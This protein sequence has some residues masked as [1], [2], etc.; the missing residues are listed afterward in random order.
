M[1]GDQGRF[2]RLVGL[3]RR[4]RVIVGAGIQAAVTAAGNLVP[5]PA[6]H[7]MAEP[8]GMMA[9]VFA[10][11]KLDEPAPD[12]A[13]VVAMLSPTLGEGV[14]RG[15]VVSTLP[16]VKGDDGMISV[17][18]N[19]RPEAYFFG[20]KDVATTFATYV[21]GAKMAEDVDADSEMARRVW[22]GWLAKRDKMGP[23]APALVY[24][25]AGPTCLAR[26]STPAAGYI[27]WRPVLTHV[28]VRV[29]M[30]GPK[31]MDVSVAPTYFETEEEALEATRA[32]G[33]P[34]PRF[35][36]TPG[37]IQNEL[38]VRNIDF[39]GPA[40]FERNA[41]PVP[42]LHFSDAMGVMLDPKAGRLPPDVHPDL[43]VALDGAT[44][45]AWRPRPDGTASLVMGSERTPM[46]WP[47]VNHAL[48]DLGTLGFLA[49]ER[50][51]VR[52]VV[53]DRRPEV[54]GARPKL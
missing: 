23:Y 10:I 54:Q 24:A 11:Q 31:G 3:L 7:A 18:R 40:V 52:L 1:S 6:A 25:V 38:A 36:Y 39:Y 37:Q 15:W 22:D 29:D 17:Q 43:Q 28:G 8:L 48:D 41:L 35:R 45:V 42:R 53:L 13:P 34:E 51:D 46:R 21:L 20:R 44:A 2:D 9:S 4:N 5:D 19:P 12:E 16:T 50:S 47:S 14:S 27:V 30:L 49:Q 32:V 26:L 33:V